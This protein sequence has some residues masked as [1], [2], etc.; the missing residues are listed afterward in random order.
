VT[1]K[2]ISFSE[3]NTNIHDSTIPHSEKVKQLNHPLVDEWISKMWYVH[4]MEYY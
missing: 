1:N 2:I 4:T 3:L